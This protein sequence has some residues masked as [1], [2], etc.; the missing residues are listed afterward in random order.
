MYKKTCGATT[1][2]LVDLFQCPALGLGKEEVHPDS[3]DYAG[4]QPDVAVSRAPVQG[5]GIDEVWGREGCE[6]GA[7]ES[8]CGGE[9]EGVASETLGWDLA[10]C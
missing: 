2:H 5:G 1:H 9:S 7:E 10:A 8:Y 3:G 6:P 4:R